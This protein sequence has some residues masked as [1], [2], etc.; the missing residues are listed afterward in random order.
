[1]VGGCLDQG[2]NPRKPDFFLKVFFSQLRYLILYLRWFS[3]H[4]FAPCVVENLRS[5]PLPQGGESLQHFDLYTPR[6]RIM[7]KRVSQISDLT[8]FSVYWYGG[9]SPCQT[10]CVLLCITIIL[11]AKYLTTQQFFPLLTEKKKFSPFIW[12]ESHYLIT[13]KYK[14]YI[15]QV[16]GDFLA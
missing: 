16:D 10:I 11:C 8:K 6:C 14:M 5:I 13:L 12:V 9:C 4:S 2:L 15:K 3:L 1:M 7:V